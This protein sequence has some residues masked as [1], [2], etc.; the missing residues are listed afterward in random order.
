MSGARGA[1]M[2]LLSTGLRSTTPTA[3]VE[4]EG[5]H[6][7]ADTNVGASSGD[8]TSRPSSALP[9]ESV[10]HDSGTEAAHQP[11]ATPSSRA[12]LPAPSVPRPPAGLVRSAS[13]GSP[14]AARRQWAAGQD[15]R[16][17][18]MDF[19]SAAVAAAA[20]ASFQRRSQRRSL[21]K[22]LTVPEN[23]VV[24]PPPA[25]L[26]A[27]TRA[28]STGWLD[29]RRKYKALRPV[30][31]SVGAARALLLPST[32]VDAACVARAAIASAERRSSKRL[33]EGE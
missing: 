23:A 26:T 20:A 32:D 31:R 11:L 21:A 22:S 8:E 9:G 33:V 15:G 25:P 24:P 19:R 17:R 12:Q 2:R 30:V 29:T 1:S 28:R 7:G 14:V 6:K 18:S 10:S 27:S 5:E 16:P 4:G 3:A 13:T